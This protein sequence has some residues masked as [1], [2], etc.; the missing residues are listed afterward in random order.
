[1]FREDGPIRPG[2]L[3]TMYRDAL[4]GFLGRTAA[5]EALLSSA[6]TCRNEGSPLA[7][8]WLDIDRFRTVND[9][10]GHLGGDA[11]IAR[12]AARLRDQ[13]SEPFSAGRMGG[14]EFLILLPG[15]DLATAQ[16]TAGRILAALRQPIELGS[17]RLHPTASLGLAMLE[18]NEDPLSTIERAE[19]AKAEAKRQGG[20]RLLLAGDEPAPGRLG[21]R[22][23]REELE[24]ENL[25]HAALESGG[26]SLHYQPVLRADESVEAVEALMRCATDGVG[27]T[28]ARFIPVAEKTGL[29]V[30][31]GEWSLLNAGMQARRLANSGRPVKVAVNVSRAQL[32]SPQFAQA[33]H[34]ALLCANVAPN[35]LELELTESLFMDMSDVVQANLRAAREA[36]VTLAIDDFGTGYSSL[37]TLKDIPAQK[38]KLDRAFVHVLPEDRRALAVVRAAAQMG[39]ELGMVVV[40]E[41]VETEGQREALFEA[42]VDAIQGFLRARPMSVEALDVWLDGH[43]RAAGLPSEKEPGHG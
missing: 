21:V 43:Y 31:L 11:V 13:L 9:S 4:T 19:R 42:G 27:L 15:R 33:M 8:L 34:A 37:A 3:T 32:T 41:G 30:R 38:L 29:I 6:A 22:L 40:A 25:L 39:R 17:L 7:A 36:G 26:L 24:V 28:P 23:A 18:K 1:M 10:F 20:D 14:D 35:L 12:I 2:L 16:A 5:L